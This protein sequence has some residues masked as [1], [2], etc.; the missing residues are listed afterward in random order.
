MVDKVTRA[1]VVATMAGDL[2]ARATSA[3]KAVIALKTAQEG[4]GAETQ[5][6][7]QKLLLTA[8]AT[9]RLV[10]KYVQ[11]YSA[12]K[13]LDRDLESLNRRFQ[14]GK[15]APDIYA[16]ALEGVARK[17]ADLKAATAE[18]SAG[19]GQVTQASNQLAAATQRLVAE[20]S[21]RKAIED[22]IASFGLQA[23]QTYAAQLDQ[24]RLKYSPLYA[25]QR[26]YL[27]TI[28]EIRVAEQV[29]ALSQVEAAAAAGKVKDAF[30][31]QIATLRGHTEQ[32]KTSTGAIQLQAHQL[33]NL[34]QQLQDVAVSLAGGQNPFLVIAQQA[35]QAAYAVGGF[36]NLVK[37]AGGAVGAVLSPIGL[38][39]TAV[40]GLTGAFA[41]GALR[42]KDISGEAREFGVVLAGMGDRA[43]ASGAKLHALVE[44]MRDLG[45]SKDDARAGVTATLR[46]PNLSA[47]GAQ[48]VSQLT[49]NF[50]AGSGQDAPTAARQLAEAVGGGYDAI[51]KLADAYR[52]FDRDPATRSLVR[53]LY[54]TGKASDGAKIVLDALGRQMEGLA[55]EKLGPTGEALNSISRAWTSWIDRV[56]A[57]APVLE[58]LN[59]AAGS[60]QLIDRITGGGESSD[61]AAL[62]ARKKK[63][64]DYKSPFPLLTDGIPGA[65][66]FETDSQS[67][68]RQIAEIDAEIAR[69]RAKLGVKPGGFGAAPGE[70]SEGIVP[71]EGLLRTERNGKELLDQSSILKARHRLVGADARTRAIGEAD[72]KTAQ[73]ALNNNYGP[74]ELKT[75][76]INNRKEA[77]LGLNEA[78]AQA[79][80]LSAIES[81][82]TL[83]VADAYRISTAAGDAA[84][85]QRQAAADAYSQ[86]ANKE[87]RARQLLLAQVNEGLTSASRA[88]EANRIEVENAKRLV[89]AQKEGVA[90]YA[91][92]ELA[93]KKQQ[94]TQ[95]LTIDIQ[96][97]VAAGAVEEAE[98]LRG[99]KALREEEIALIDRYSKASSLAA[100]LRKADQDI[101]LAGLQ[102]TISKLTDVNERRA[103][104]IALARQMQAIQLK[105]DPRYAG[106]Q[107][108]QDALLSKGDQARA[109]QDN[110]R[111]FDEVRQQAEGLSK[112]VSQFLVD[113]FV[114]ANQGGKSAFENLWQGALAGAKRF[115]AQVAAQFLQQRILMPI[116]MQIVGGSPG[117]FGVSN[118]GGSSGTIQGTPGIGDLLGGARSIGGGGGFSGLT[119]S[120]DSVGASLGF[121]AA[122]QAVGGWT[123]TG[124]GGPSAAGLNA[125]AGGLLGGTTLSQAL[126]FAGVGLSAIMNFASG[127]VG[128]GVGNLAGAGIGFAN[129]GQIG[130]GIGAALGGV[131]GGLFGGKKPTVGPGGGILF[132]VNADGTA[133][134]GGGSG[135][136]G[137]DY[138]QQG[139]ID[140]ANAVGKTVKTFIETVGGTF[141]GSHANDNR[142]GDLG[143]DAGKKK[144]TGGD[145]SGGKGRYDTFEEAFKATVV[146]VLKDSDFTGLSKDIGDRVKA[147]TSNAD[148]DALLQYIDGLTLIYNG[149]KDWKEPLTQVETGMASLKATLEAAK[150]AAESLSKPIDDVTASYEKQRLYLVDQFNAPLKDREL[151][152]TGRSGEA[153]L[154]NFDRNAAI[155]R[156]DA[157]ALG[158]EAV[159]QAE[160]TLG[161]ERAAIVKKNADDELKSLIAMREAVVARNQAQIAPMK[162]AYDGLIGELKSLR[163]VWKGIAEAMIKF[164]DSLKV[165]PLSTLSPLDQMREAQ[166]Q[167]SVTLAKARAGDATAAG[168]LS[169][170]AQTALSQTQ[171]YYASGQGYADYFN[172]VQNDLT[173]VSDYASQ[174]VSLADQQ[175]GVQKSIDSSARTIA[176]ILT[177]L[178]GVKTQIAAAGGYE[179]GL[180][181]GLDGGGFG[182]ATKS[183]AD[184]IRDAYGQIGRAANDDEVKA[185]T[186]LVASGKASAGGAF[187]SIVYNQAALNPLGV[188]TPI[189]D[190]GRPVRKDLIIVDGS[191]PGG[192]QNNPDILKAIGT[193]PQFASGGDHVGGPRIVGERGAELEFTGPSTIVSNDRAR[194]FFAGNDN[195]VQA[196]LRALRAENAELRRAILVSGKRQTA[197]LVEAIMEGNETNRRALDLT[198]RRIAAPTPGARSA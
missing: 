130:L 105:N 40:V 112:D 185:W 17:A 45:V 166:R 7:E 160:L 148:M 144:Y 93:I 14:A 184:N 104:E 59:R 56:A 80:R 176:Q 165:G 54:E 108:A 169:N 48:A 168:E 182:D 115:A 139:N 99:L 97:A 121:S 164:R 10:G 47:A 84:A 46:N 127:N 152:I 101:E 31:A 190:I 75:R 193:T 90:A 156:R 16:Q 103:A 33:T 120:I 92:V 196:E 187:A 87:T 195:G 15:I 39:A 25:A 52:V 32:V 109:L 20:Q 86:G 70:R 26:R 18:M 34:G 22:Q 177:D 147:V 129:G 146:S 42:A 157:A 113:G 102:A 4:L 192:V 94:A 175:L 60:I 74:D 51:M 174:Q 181:K 88:T 21:K 38:A 19:M 69:Q 107:A 65:L 83:K 194:A 154:I 188:T 161:L 110:A 189:N 89:D 143:W 100:D 3:A 145:T 41:L 44:S 116:A 57:S 91:E 27:E 50:A 85:A 55:K 123:V 171:S 126:P 76:A 72:I 172:Q 58:L 163:D 82:E 29:G 53:T 12:T 191:D 67:T 153:D 122:P 37:I 125:G 11:G 9:D 134:I 151:R 141:L 137:Y 81:A 73:E 197:A 28:K 133:K 43:A 35:P 114:N 78:Q 131:L 95:Q 64:Q 136:N 155:T 159:K 68:A 150:S 119:S 167:Y 132:G 124:I 8:S 30:S 135:D 63:L 117:S 162:Q 23:Y 173:G 186:D 1:D 140:N 180:G 6:T 2:E 79:A 61:I 142:G 111:F 66:G 24:L 179:T 49:P 106:D 77:L 96:K 158:A 71:T 128:G 36:G 118:P 183:L 98:W 5:R 149:F 178:Y 13:Q 170:Y 62:E 138:L 198:S